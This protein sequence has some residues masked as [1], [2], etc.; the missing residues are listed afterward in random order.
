MKILV[1]L[2]LILM[3]LF[4]TN[5]QTS[6]PRKV[7]RQMIK[8]EKAE[9]KAEKKELEQLLIKAKKQ[10]LKNQNKETR[11]MMRQSKRYNRKLSQPA[12]K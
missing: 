6:K 5:C 12:R 4:T 3:M 10:H 9:E 1:W 8:K 7:E 2:L 11:K